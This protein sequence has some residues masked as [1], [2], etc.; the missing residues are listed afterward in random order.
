MKWEGGSN[1]QIGARRGTILL[2]LLVLLVSLPSFFMPWSLIDDGESI[3]RS[4]EINRFLGS[5]DYGSISLPLIEQDHGRFRPLYWLYLWVEYNLFG[6][7]AR[8]HHLG[9]ILLFVVVVLL[10]S[11]V[12]KQI[13]GSA[14]AGV[15]SGLLFALSPLTIDNWHRLGPGEPQL[16][17]WQVASL[18]FL[19][20]AYL[21]AERNGGRRPLFYLVLS[22]AILPLSYFSKETS[23][24]LV[25]VSAVMFLVMGLSSKGKGYCSSRTLFFVYFMANLACGLASGGAAQLLTAG[26]GYTVHYEIGIHRILGTSRHYA[27]FLFGGYHLLLVIALVGFS[28][29]LVHHL[30]KG[31]GLGRSLK[32]QIIMLFWFIAALGVL[33][34]WKYA[35]GR[36][37]LP[38]L[39][40]L[41]VFMGVELANLLSSVRFFWG[42]KPSRVEGTNW[43]THRCSLVR[44]LRRRGVKAIVALAYLTFAV[45]AFEGIWNSATFLVQRDGVNAETVRFL[46]GN[47]GQGHRLYLNLGPESE[48]FYETGLHLR[49]FYDRDDIVVRCLDL[50]SPQSYSEGDFLASWSEHGRYPINLLFRSLGKRTT[51]TRTIHRK[52]AV[53]HIKLLSRLEKIVQGRSQPP[54]FWNNYFGWW[55]FQFVVPSRTGSQISHQIGQ[56]HDA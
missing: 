5:A 39:I 56:Y 37:L 8:Y 10:I 27:A 45:A 32:W 1:L 18:Y 50:G 21:K 36:Y 2:V 25:P 31:G 24:A 19:G 9:R 44:K 40:G 53:L 15:L 28:I 14:R 26:G 41:S 6:L 17:L 46:A 47:L 22:I 11:G 12:A 43:D 29:R 52:Q 3:R 33:L 49:L 30:Y 55:I 34:P 4:Q 48:W 23:I 16:V 38:C 54:L 13:A 42:R 20:R 35:L 7:N 51:V